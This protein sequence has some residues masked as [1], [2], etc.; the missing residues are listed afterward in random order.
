M[1]KK[2]GRMPVFERKNGGERGIRTPGGLPLVGFQDRCLKPLDHLST[3]P[4]SAR[5]YHKRYS[6]K[7]KN[8]GGSGKKR[9]SAE[10]NLKKRACGECPP[11]RVVPAARIL[12]RAVPHDLANRR[13]PRPISAFP[14][15][16][17]PLKCYIIWI[18]ILA[19]EPFVRIVIST[20]QGPGYELDLG[21]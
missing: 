16:F 3:A 18:R 8:Q 20:G 7:G 2:W 11:C 10:K 4:D 5:R 19:G 6:K 21:D 14:L 17:A 12:R 1:G 15:D 9:P 13:K